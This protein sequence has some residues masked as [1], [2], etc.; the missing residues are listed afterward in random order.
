MSFR[1][2][3][4]IMKKITTYSIVIGLVVLFFTL[5]VANVLASPVVPLFVEKPYDGFIK[6]NE[7]QNFSIWLHGNKTYVIKLEKN[8][9][10]AYMWISVRN[11]TDSI[12]PNSCKTIGSVDEYTIPIKKSGNYFI[13]V[14]SNKDSYYS[15]KVKD[16]T[17]SPEKLVGAIVLLVG[18]IAF[19]YPDIFR[20]FAEKI[21]WKKIGEISSLTKLLLYISASINFLAGIKTLFFT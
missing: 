20:K 21:K 16:M 11:A 1:Q 18:L 2:R 3:G 8:S 4:E 6:A 17:L 10:D 15:I 12:H 13:T 9:S 19:I 7:T 5:I 14:F